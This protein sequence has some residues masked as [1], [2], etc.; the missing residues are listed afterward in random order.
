MVNVK[1]VNV[2]K[3]W[4][5]AP[6]APPRAVRSVGQ[7]GKDSVGQCASLLASE[8]SGSIRRLQSACTSCTWWALWPNQA[9]AVCLYKLHMVSPLPQ[10]GARSLPVQAAHG[11]PSGPNQ[12]PAVCLYKLHMVSPLPQSGTRSLPVQA[13][14]GEPSGPIRRP[15]SA[16]TSCTWWALCPNQA[17]AVCL[18]KLHMVSPLAQSGARSL[19]VQAAHGEPSAPIRY[20]QSACTSCTWWA[21]CPN[22]APA[23]CLYKLHMVSPLARSGACSLPVQA[24]HGEPSGPI[25]RLQSA[26]TSC[27]WWALLWLTSVWI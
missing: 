15:Q 11:E 3:I 22:Q 2:I 27:T 12:A 10:S 4:L 5:L 21:L 19:P 25:R 20:P 17:P 1:C 13:A 24:A 23:V 16:C 6:L 18:Y 9:P 14:H 26:C 8:P 7:E